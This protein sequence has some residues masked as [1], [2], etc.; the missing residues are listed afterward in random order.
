MSE[1][2]AWAT[3]ALAQRPDHILALWSSAIANA[4]S[5]DI[6]EARRFMPRIRQLHPE[7]RLSTLKEYYPVRRPEEFEMLREGLRLAGLPE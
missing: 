4:L 5:G 7:L 3:R 6:E 1:G 2:L